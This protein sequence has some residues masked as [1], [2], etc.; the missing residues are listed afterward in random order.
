M[1]AFFLAFTEE[2]QLWLCFPLKTFSGHLLPEQIQGKA[3]IS[4][5]FQSA[6]Q[7]TERDQDIYPHEKTVYQE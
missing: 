4:H 1:K 7:I 5:I 3:Y 2:K 6:V